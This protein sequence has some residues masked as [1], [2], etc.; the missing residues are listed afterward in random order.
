VLRRAGRL[1]IPAL[2]SS[3]A[4][5]LLAQLGAFEASPETTPGGVRIFA[6]TASRRPTLGAQLGDWA[7]E[8]AGLLAPWETRQL[9]PPDLRYGVQLW[10]IPLELWASFVLHL[11]LLALGK[12]RP[13]P[14]RVLLWV[15]MAYYFAYGRW[16]LFLF[17][18]GMA[19]TDAQLVSRVR[20]AK[21]WEPPFAWA[22][23][24]D[25]E[26]RRRWKST[27]RN[28]VA[29]LALIVGLYLLSQPDIT[30][31]TTTDKVKQSGLRRLAESFVPPALADDRGRLYIAI[32]APIVLYAMESGPAAV[33]WICNTRVAQYMGSISFALYLVHNAVIRSIGVWMLRSFWNEA[34]GSMH[35]LGPI[36]IACATLT[37]SLLAA[38]LFYRLVDRPTNRLMKRIVEHLMP[39]ELE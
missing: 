31:P 27:L 21:I 36:S 29:V 19:L 12:L 1:L 5:M 20:A 9:T 37:I 38:D 6:V 26:R 8:T 18:A 16:D 13:A 10:T 7:A 23:L 28:F 30:I 35:H 33:R 4:V 11:H 32:S 22:V 34:E 39:E 24:K 25:G 2:A 3:F 15:S 14:R 17:L